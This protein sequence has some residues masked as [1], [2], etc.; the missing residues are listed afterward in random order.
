MLYNVGTKNLCTI[1]LVE[2]QL[3]GICQNLL[4]SYNKRFNTSD[5][6][7]TLHAAF[8]SKPEFRDDEDLIKY[9]TKVINDIVSNICGPKIKYFEESSNKIVDGYYRFMKYLN[10]SCILSKN[11]ISAD[12]SLENIYK[13]LHK[14][15]IRTYSEAM[16]ET[17]RK[18]H[19]PSKLR[20]R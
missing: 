4:N 1:C 13:S 14:K 19:S 16:A 3:Q 6:V 9:S 12:L 8:G 17:K 7:I 11:N 20:K 5:L 10:D 18:K 15:I 2:E